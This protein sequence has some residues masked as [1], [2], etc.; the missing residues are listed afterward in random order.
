MMTTEL[1]MND[2]SIT[3]D[4]ALSKLYNHIKEQGQLQKKEHSFGGIWSCDT[5]V[6]GEIKAQLCDDGYTQSVVY[7]GGKVISKTDRF[8]VQYFSGGDFYSFVVEYQ[9]YFPGD[10]IL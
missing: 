6:L 9:K 4:Q 1:N 7:A 10:L 2:V 8:P 5:W 3:I